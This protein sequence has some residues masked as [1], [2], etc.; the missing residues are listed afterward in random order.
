MPARI[1]LVAVSPIM[2]AALAVGQIAPPSPAERL[3][4]V[5]D[6]ARAQPVEVFAD[7]A[8]AVLDHLP[9]KEKPAVLEE[10]F[11][12]ATAA[13]NPL[14]LRSAIRRGKPIAGGAQSV[15]DLSQ[16]RNAAHELRLDGLSL[17]CRAI[18][19]L[20]AVNPK[21]ARELIE[22][23]P[24]VEIPKAECKDEFVPDTS[25]YIDA[26][27]A[28]A[29][30]GAFSR[31]EKEKG[32]P[33]FLV[34]QAARRPSTSWEAAGAAK[35]LPGFARTEKEAQILAAALV[36]SLGLPDSDRGFSS[37]V[38]AGSLVENVVAANRLLHAS[39]APEIL[40]PALRAYLVRHLRGVRCKDG[41][42]AAA[43]FVTAF[44]SA[45][46][47]RGDVAPITA[48]EVKPAGMGDAMKRTEYENSAEF[49]DLWSQIE[50]LGP[51]GTK[52]FSATRMTAEWRS[53]ARQALSR[54]EDWK[55]AA[56]QD[57]VEVFHQKC[58]LLY[59]IFDMTPAGPTRD[60]AVNGMIALFA[61]PII[62]DKSPAE[63]LQELQSSVRYFETFTPAFVNAAR[64]LVEG[65]P[66][67]SN[68][69][70]WQAM[71]ESRFSALALYGRI[72]LLK[73][74]EVASSPAH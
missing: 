10:I 36:G 4:A 58:A 46:R 67:G 42:P 25:V 61:D 12:R 17:Q 26:L 13:R 43:P 47:E 24:R 72:G 3:R 51:T 34:E 11:H 45:I 21:L 40:L 8:F 60:I 49:R 41:E 16:V 71:A 38:L 28:V 35:T 53:R 14:P 2:L 32:L 54:I 56:G 23:I 62:L 37:A 65:F 48:D 15:L 73:A 66:E 50:A 6:E 70:I 5:L 19:E 31:E 18:Q 39:G 22:E 1:V 59:R 30:R 33:W 20:L 9:A 57:D 44:N 63:W 52:N 68:R 64:T 69:E 55:G 29:E 7:I 27:A 74:E